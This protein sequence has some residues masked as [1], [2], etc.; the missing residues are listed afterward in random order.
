MDTTDSKRW[1]DYG[2]V[3]SYLG[4]LAVAVLGFWD[5]SQQVDQICNTAEEN[6]IAITN[7][8]SAVER[9][10]EDLVLEGKPPST[11]TPE[12]Q[13]AIDILMDFKERQMKLLDE[14]VCTE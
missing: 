1:Y 12:E 3:M 8:V 4:I 6:R 11:A 13:R 9:L 10:G 7:V 5:S 2:W 14:P